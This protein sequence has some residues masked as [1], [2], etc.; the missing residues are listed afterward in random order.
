MYFQTQ[1][2]TLYP[3]LHIFR[4]S[5]CFSPSQWWVAPVI[6]SICFPQQD[7]VVEK[8]VESVQQHRTNQEI[9]PP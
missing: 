8:T 4:H 1:G 7:Q 2:L 5:A 3:V 9:H 6:D